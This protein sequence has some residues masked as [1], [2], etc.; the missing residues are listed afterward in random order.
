MKSTFARF[1]LAVAALSLLGI[2]AF[3]QEKKITAK[4]VPGPVLTAFKTAYPTA[5]VRGYA[6]EKENGKTFYEIES[7]DGARHRDIL[8]NADGSI[9]EIEEGIAATDLPAEAQQTLKQK[10]PKAVVTTAEKVTI[11][12]KVAYEVS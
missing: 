3:G 2:S 9:S 6:L 7:I 11:G 8:Y 5:K 1:V 10:Y 4:Q 12:D